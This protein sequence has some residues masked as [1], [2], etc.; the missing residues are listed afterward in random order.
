MAKKKETTEKIPKLVLSEDEVVS[1][2]Q[3]RADDE[4]LKRQA[5]KREKETRQNEAQVEELRKSLN[6][7]ESMDKDS[8][9][10]QALKRKLSKK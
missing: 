8:A 4:L 1:I 9:E 3:V 6:D 5:P 10:Y 7:I 2:D